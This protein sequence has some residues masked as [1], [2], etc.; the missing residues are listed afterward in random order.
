MAARLAAELTTLP[1]AHLLHPVQANELFVTVAARVREG[2]LAD[3]FKFYPWAAGGPNCIRLVTAFNT[4]E[5]DITALIEAA[6]RLC[7]RYGRWH[8][9]IGRGA[10]TRCWCP[11]ISAKSG[12]ASKPGPLRLVA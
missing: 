5:Q 4:S 2:L 10:K 6:R 9:R 7:R 3:G 12:A 11:Y 8:R 1:G